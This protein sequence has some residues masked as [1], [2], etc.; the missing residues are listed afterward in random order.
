ERE[1]DFVYAVEEDPLLDPADVEI[2]CMS[3][4]KWGEEVF[5]DVVDPRKGPCLL[6]RVDVAGGC[7]NA[8][9]V[10]VARGRAAKMADPGLREAAAGGARGDFL[11]NGCGLFGKAGEFMRR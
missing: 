3:S 2:G 4:V 11:L 10:S 5:D 8:K 1:N 9:G 7:E 6:D